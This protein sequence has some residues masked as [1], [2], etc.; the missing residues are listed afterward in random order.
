MLGDFDKTAPRK[1][2]EGLT[3]DE[4]KT[5]IESRAR[6]PHAGY[7]PQYIKKALIDLHAPMH[8]AD[9]IPHVLYFA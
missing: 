3:S 5:F 2:T 7:D 9:S 6:K 8:I 4:F 1:G